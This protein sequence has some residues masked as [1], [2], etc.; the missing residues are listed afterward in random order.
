MDVFVRGF[1][2][3]YDYSYSLLSGDEVFIKHG[4]RFSDKTY[5][6]VDGGISWDEYPSSLLPLTM[7]MADL[8]EIL[9][10]LILKYP[11][12]EIFLIK[13]LKSTFLPTIVRISNSNILEKMKN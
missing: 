2:A 10:V 1:A 12:T 13:Q 3:D 4:E 5:H 9:R 7:L 8:L 6:T 11:M